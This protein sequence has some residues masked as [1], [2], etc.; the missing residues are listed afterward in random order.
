MNDLIHYGRKRRGI[1][2][3]LSK[4]ISE[5]LKSIKDEK[6]R[7]L[8]SKDVIVTGGAIASMLLGEN[9]NDFD[10]YFR[11]KSTTI[12]IA[13]YYTKQ[14]NSV[15]KIK[16][17]SGVVPY[18]PTVIEDQ[19]ENCKGI[20]EDRVIIFMKSAGVVGE[21]QK[22]YHYFENMSETATINFVNSTANKIKKT[23][24]KYK[25]VFLTNNAITLTGKIQLVIRFFGEPEEIHN[26]YDFI[27]AMCYFDYYS[28]NLVL[29]PRALE[30]LLS[31]TLI[32]NGSLYPVASIFRMKKFIERGWRIT[33]GQQLKIIWQIS[34]LNLTD[35]G[36]LRE[37]LIG[38]DVAYMYQLIESVKE[39]QNKG[40]E[41][42]STYLA[43]LIDRLFD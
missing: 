36:V 19:I 30:C 13:E 26:N 42:D 24:G 27:H 29:P 9:V 18:E 6:V 4:K 34:E 28:K 15:N 14:F 2:A 41:I 31:R 11:T 38:V 5:W 8:A 40:E 21:K 16:T 17:G 25:P 22:D 20:I 37:Q 3:E 12:K 10:L 1:K 39:M 35:L 32:Y 7:E 23:K 43:V 33:A